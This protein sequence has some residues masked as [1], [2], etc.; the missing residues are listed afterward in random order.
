[1]AATQQDKSDLVNGNQSEYEENEGALNFEK[2]H[3]EMNLQLTHQ[4]R[5]RELSKIF[6]QV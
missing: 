1:M 2:N 5:S 4:I 6:R 3:T